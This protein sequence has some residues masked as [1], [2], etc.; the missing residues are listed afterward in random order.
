M[1]KNKSSIILYIILAFFCLVYL[2]SAN[3]QTNDS[4]EIDLVDVIP[5]TLKFHFDALSID[6]Y[7]LSSSG[8][9]KKYLDYPVKTFLIHKR[10]NSDSCIGKLDSLKKLVVNSIMNSDSFRFDV[11]A[12]AVF[13]PKLF[14]LNSL[15]NKEYPTEK[16][17]AKL[18]T[19][20][21]KTIIPYFDISSFDE[22]SI[23]GD[24]NTIT[25][26]K[27]N[28]TIHILKYGLHNV[29]PA[30]WTIKNDWLPEKVRHGYITGFITQEGSSIIRL[31]TCVW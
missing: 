4:K 5:D 23:L 9:K 10:V 3:N 11:L 2:N 26:L 24:K 21:T 12:S 6:Q 27:D 29:M 1:K 28:C 8:V 17:K 31:W 30:E 18:S 25:G 7:S 20:G 14:N 19:Y 16:I 22:D 15:K 13:L